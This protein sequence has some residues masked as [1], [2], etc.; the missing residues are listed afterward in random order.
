IRAR[1]PLQHGRHHQIGDELMRV[2]HADRLWMIVGVVAAVALS[3]LSWM[4]F[5]GPQRSQTGGLHDQAASTELRLDT[6]RHQL[7]KLRQE[8][9]ALPELRS[10][11]DSLRQALPVTHET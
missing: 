11:V 4:V 2:K 9:E 3:A 8:N 10:A 5:I 7:A 6:L 1:R